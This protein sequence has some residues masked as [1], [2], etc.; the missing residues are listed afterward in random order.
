MSGNSQGTSDFDEFVA[1]GEVEIGESNLAS[2]EEGDEEEKPSR[3]P[4]RPPRAPKS[5]EKETP[6]AKDDDDGASD[7]DEDQNGEGDEDDDEDEK[8]V[9]KPRSAKDRIRELNARNRELER[10]LDRVEKGGLPNNST[11]DKPN[12]EAKAAPD[13]MDAA[14]YPLGHLDD[15]YIEDRI[16]WVADKKAAERADAVLQRQQENEQ[17]ASQQQQQAELLEKVDDLADRGADLHDDFQEIVVEAGMRG[18]WKLT[19]TTFEACHEADN[20]AAILLGLAQDKKEAARVAGLSPLAQLKYVQEKDAELGGKKPRTKPQAG[21][22]PRNTPRGANSRVQGN[23]A[24]N[25]LDDFEK[26]WKRSEGR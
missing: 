5:T 15:R 6:A 3:K 18:D 22:P 21:E 26:Q 7:D 14:K 9:K 10:R 1:A 13:P 16:E 17:I 12:V 2:Q 11:A 20:G 4:S 8:P 23:P 19:Q 25:D 24:T